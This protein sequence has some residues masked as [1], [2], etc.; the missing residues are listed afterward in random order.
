M[1]DLLRVENLAVEFRTMAG[2]TRAVNGLSFRVEPGKTVAIVGESGSGKSVTAQAIMGILPPIARRLDGRIL[3][4]E[5]GASAVD[6][7][8]LDTRSKE[9]AA[10][11][12][13]RISM[14]FQEPTTSFSAYHT[15]GDQIGE[16]LKIHRG[17]DDKTA[18]KA[19]VEGLA[20]VGFPNPETKV[21]AYPFELSGGLCQRAM[22]AMAMICKPAL[23]I[24]DEPT[25]ALDVT[26]QAE[27]LKLMKAMQEAN[28][29]AILL[30]AHD[31][32][33][34]A[35]M[36]DEMVVVHHGKAM[37]AGT[38][39]DLFAE[40]RHPYLKALLAA[41]PRFDMLPGER[42]TPIREI[43]VDM[44]AAGARRTALG[45]GKDA[46][47][48]AEG[49]VL[50]MVRGIEKGFTSR[51]ETSW[52]KKAKAPSSLAVAGVDLD[53]R[54]GE[55]LG[56][57]GES[58]CGKTTL[59]KIIV[60]SIEA[61]AGSVEMAGDGGRIDV[62]KLEGEP[63]RDWRRRV[64]YVFQNPYS[65]LNPRMTVLSILSEP[66]VIHGIGDTKSRRARVSEL[67][68]LVG[69]DDSHMNRYPH[70]F[71]GG[72]RQRLGIARALALEPELIIFDEPVSALDV[73]IQAQILNLLRDLRSALGLTYLF[74]SHNLAVVDYLADRIAVM[75]AGRI[76]E[77]APREALFRNALHPYTKALIAA[78]PQPDPSRRL[79]FARISLERQS[80]PCAWAAPFGA[81]KTGEPHLVKIGP[82][83][84]VRAQKDLAMPV[85]LPPMPASKGELG[86]RTPGEHA[87]IARALAI[88]PKG[89]PVVHLD[90]ETGTLDGWSVRRLVGPHSAR[91]QG[92]VKRV[93]TK[94]CRFELRPGDRV[95]QGIRAELRDWYNAPFET[96]TWYGFATYLAEDFAPPRETGV[97]LAQWHDQARLGDPSGKPPLAIRYLDGRLRFTGAAS[98]VASPDPETVHL[99]HET[100]EVALGRWM[101]FVFRIHWSRHGPSEI[102]AFL[103][104][105]PLFSFRGPLGY[106]NED[107][108]PYFKLGLYASGPIETPLVGYHD[109]YS[110]GPGYDAVDP[111][112]VHRLAVGAVA[113]TEPA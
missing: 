9:F 88:D 64:Q 83:H 55:C 20:A 112:R 32:G 106:P 4:Q 51:S 111:A 86:G 27:I 8:G 97:V 65:A 103:D 53:I 29:T 76:V 18:R 22:I 57:V 31:L 110:R 48:G 78:V 60:R 102:D 71:S 101:D 17:A 38:A 72:Q 15:I 6:L 81:D 49:E 10:I 56:L 25:T 19:A 107:Q 68:R 62:L 2:T 46:R 14:I 61:D 21:D 96:D 82:G 69:L 89:E 73:S 50:L 1:S 98:P 44:A 34:V 30:I 93:G 28:G 80:D 67:L 92:E 33:V 99:F 84:F 74:I 52:F 11:R 113:V 79:D 100:A 54:R 85:S 59:S 58:G 63:L 39:A 90:F 70:S 16:A 5:K 108:A 47:A 35:N 40:P 104:G 109:N 3:F 26:V 87:E 12:G 45:R 95:S 13:A 75:A 77:L 37:E 41:V 24:A 7:A 42:L 91:V 36:A 23:L 94:A 66:L 105:K 43:K